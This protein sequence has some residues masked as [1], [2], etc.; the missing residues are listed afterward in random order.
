MANMNAQLL[1]MVPMMASQPSCAAGVQDYYKAL[2]SDSVRLARLRTKVTAADR[3]AALTEAMVRAFGAHLRTIPYTFTP[4]A[5]LEMPEPWYQH[6][7]S[8]L[9][10]LAAQRTWR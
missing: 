4:G 3:T 1:M 10:E 6:T 7:R 8:F 9:D 2:A 5:G